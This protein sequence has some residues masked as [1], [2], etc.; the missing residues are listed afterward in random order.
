MKHF[1]FIAE[2]ISTSMLSQIKSKQLIALRISLVQQQS[3][4]ANEK[5]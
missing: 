1:D 4:E 5:T 3:E 2:N